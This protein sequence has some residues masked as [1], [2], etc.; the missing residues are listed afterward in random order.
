M[1]LRRTWAWRWLRAAAIGLGAGS[2]FLI[3]LGM[4]FGDDFI[5]FP[6][7]EAPAETAK[8]GPYRV[9]DVSL[10]AADGTKLHAWHIRSGG[11]AG[12]VLFF[13]GN[14]GTVADRSDLYAALA[15]LGFDVFAQ[16]Y[17]GYGRSEGSPSEQGIYLDAEAAYRHLVESVGVPPSKLLLYGESLGGAPA[18]WLA[19][20]NP[21]AGVVLQCPFSSIRDMALTIIPF[22]P[23]H[24]FMAS[25]FDNLDHIRSV[26]APKLIIA[27][28]ND[29][30]VPVRLTR[31][32]FDAAPQPKTWVELER[33]GHND[34]WHV[35]R[36]TCEE[37]L[38]RF[39]DQTVSR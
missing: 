24:W 12:T 2:S 28:R 23:V 34:V 32:L 25:K 22:F 17:R 39:R 27:A 13:H 37:A 7:R 5:F 31:K 8:R 29:E 11:S 18:L 36:S 19:S 38:A 14:A 1:S 15:R 16:E 4:G 9:D 33:G 26:A 21:C 35:N 20:R 10:V 6:S 30:V 3:I